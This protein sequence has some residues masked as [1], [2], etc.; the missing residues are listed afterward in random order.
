MDAQSRVALLVAGRARSG[1]STFARVAREEGFADFTLAGPLKSLT[2][3]VLEEAYGLSLSLDQMNGVD[4]D[5]NTPLTAPFPVHHAR[6][7]LLSQAVVLLSTHLLLVVFGLSAVVSFG[8]FALVVFAATTAAAHSLETTRM[9]LNIGT[10]MLTVR[11]ALQH[12]GTQWCQEHIGKDVWIQHLL[13]RVAEARPPRLVV[14]DLRFPLEARL[15]RAGLSM[16]GY[17]T[18]ALR[19]ERDWRNVLVA[20]PRDVEAHASEAQVDGLPVDSVLR[21]AGVDIEDFER[22]CREEV[23]AVLGSSG[24]RGRARGYGSPG[25]MKLPL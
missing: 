13:R 3:L 4:Y 23:V 10:R 18:H 20:Q 5:R 17:S 14:S 2:R 16:Q 21:N 15:L 22:A 9:P 6:S 25:D 7:A 1:K 24:F 8:C 12:V 11:N 19:V